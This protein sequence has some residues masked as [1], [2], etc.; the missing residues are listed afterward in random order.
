MKLWTLIK[1]GIFII[2]LAILGYILYVTI[3]TWISSRVDK[4]L[5]A[6]ENEESG[7]TFDSQKNQN[8]YDDNP[9]EVE[10]EYESDVDEGYISDD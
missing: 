1:F 3:N 4:T 9:K 10:L 6:D 7:M 8:S 5:R 2:V